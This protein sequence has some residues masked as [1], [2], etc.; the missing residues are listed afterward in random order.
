MDA[1]RVIAA[2]TAAAL[3]AGVKLGYGTAG[4]RS[5]AALLDAVFIRMGMLAALRAAQQ[6]AS[7]GVMVTAS[8]NPVAD[9]G[10]KMVDVD[11]GMLHRDWEKVRRPHRVEGGGRAPVAS[12][13][14]PLPSP[15]TRL[16]CCAQLAR[17]PP[18]PHYLR[19]CSM[20]AAWPSPT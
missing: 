13:A 2:A 1:S 18:P 4:F 19:A 7:V 16:S 3:P 6:G 5:K 8:H 10:V 11:G 9:N 14:L 17:P 15:L 12:V 20:P